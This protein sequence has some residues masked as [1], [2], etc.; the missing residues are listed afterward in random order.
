MTCGCL[1]TDICDITCFSFG[2]RESCAHLSH[3]G[4]HQRLN[5]VHQNRFVG[6]LDQRLGS[7]ERQ[8]SQSRAVAADQDERP[9]A[10]CG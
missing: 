7:A 9:H 2:R 6:E 10:G 3:A 4:F 8:R 1:I 5:L